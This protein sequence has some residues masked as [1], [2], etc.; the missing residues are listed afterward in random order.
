MQSGSFKRGLSGKKGVD[1]V[2]EMG[3][4]A[5]RLPKRRREENGVDVRITKVYDKGKDGEEKGEEERDVPGAAA[6]RPG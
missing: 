3:L 4:L 5:S 6:A 2:G 1:V